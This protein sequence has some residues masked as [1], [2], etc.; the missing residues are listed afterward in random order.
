MARPVVRQA[1]A[2]NLLTKM[3]HFWSAGDTEPPISYKYDYFVLIAKGKIG[4]RVGSVNPSTSVF[5]APH[6]VYVKADTPYGLEAITENA[7]AYAVYALRD[8]E[9]VLLDVDMV[10][11]KAEE[12]ADLVRRLK[13]FSDN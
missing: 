12:L 3:Y 7:V 10:P 6:I 11:D 9:G 2:G 8:T 1:K 4:V 5:I 13:S